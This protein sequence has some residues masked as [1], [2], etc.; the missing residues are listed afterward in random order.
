MSQCCRVCCRKIVY[1]FMC[2]SVC[3]S[4]DVY[5]FI[6]ELITHAPSLVPT[7][8]PYFSAHCVLS[9]SCG[10]VSGFLC[11]AGAAVVSFSNFVTMDPTVANLRCVCRCLLLIM[12]T[13]LSSKSARHPL[14]QNMPIESSALF[15]RSE[16]MC[17]LCFDGES[18]LRK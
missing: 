1:I 7:F 13:F 12:C 6:I 17:A 3:C 15:L 5:M 9:G 8:V 16:K 4:D 10:H 2:D 14:L 18:V 11:F